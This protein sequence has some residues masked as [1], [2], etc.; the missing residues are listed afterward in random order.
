MR[1]LRDKAGTI[2]RWNDILAENP[3]CVEVTEQ[4]A[5]PE[6]FVPEKQKGRKAKMS[7]T[8]DTIPEAPIL[9]NED[10]NLEA[11]RGL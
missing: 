1:F 10:L 7:L 11:S 9:T 8:T 2:Y 6:K 4:E 3:D 5:F